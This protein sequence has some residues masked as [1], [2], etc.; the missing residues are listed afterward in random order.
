MFQLIGATLERVGEDEEADELRT[1]LRR[2]QDNGG[3]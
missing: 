2:E 1:W 3:R